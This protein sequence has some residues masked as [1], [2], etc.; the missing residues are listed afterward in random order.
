VSTMCRGA[1]PR[2]AANSRLLLKTAPFRW[3]I[4]TAVDTSGPTSATVH[5]SDRYWRS[6]ADLGWLALAE[7]HASATTADFDSFSRA[8]NGVR[9]SLGVSV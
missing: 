2:Q 5:N 3:Q 9:T 4:T 8:P 6:V 1:S 7:A